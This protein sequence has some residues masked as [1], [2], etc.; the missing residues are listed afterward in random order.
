[1]NEVETRVKFADTPRDGKWYELPNQQYIR[2]N[3]ELGMWNEMV[4][5]NGKAVTSGHVAAGTELFGVEE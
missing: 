4:I 5:R 1:M 3:F 2:W